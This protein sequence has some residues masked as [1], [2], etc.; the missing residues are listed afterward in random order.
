VEILT[1]KILVIQT[2]FL[3]DSILTLPFLQLL[4]KENTEAVI[5]VVSTLQ[6]AEIFEASPVVDKV[7]PLDKKGE[8]KSILK[9][10]GF[11]GRLADEKYTK[12]YSLHRSFRTS[13]LVYFSHVKE[14]YGYDTASASFVYKHKIRYRKSFH[15]VRRLMSFLQNDV[16]EDGWRVIPEI[17]SHEKQTAE[18][19]AYIRSL[20]TAKKI[21]AIAPGSVW[22]TKRYPVEYYEEII[23]YFSGRD[24][25]IILLGG[26]DEHEL[27]EYLAKETNALN[28]CGIFSLIDVHRILRECALLICNDSALAH[29]GVSANIP[30]EMIYCSTIPEFGFYPY[31]DKG[32]FDS[33]H[34]LPCK[35]CGIHGW[36]VCPERHFNC[37]Y[38]LQ[39]EVVMKK[40]EK[41]LHGE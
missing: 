8:H 40:A 33:L 9:T 37:G 3:G 29:L 14:T 25:S 6:S 15:E 27:C 11:A 17:N 4:K 20:F 2:S 35:P 24:Y 23:R 26:K 19:D 7:I 13:I 18:T 16:G 10:I 36:R 22:A 12:L 34:D 21:I 41:L 30:V 32:D 31:H 39:P 5:H 28:L 38:L 1:H